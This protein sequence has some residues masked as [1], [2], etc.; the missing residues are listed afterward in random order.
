[1]PRP[2]RLLDSWFKKEFRSKN[3]SSLPHEFL[4]T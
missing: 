1:M 2:N 4:F 3:V